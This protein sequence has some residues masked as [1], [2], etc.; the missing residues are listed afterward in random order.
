[1]ENLKYSWKIEN[2]LKKNTENLENVIYREIK[3]Y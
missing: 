1:M 3:L 2:F